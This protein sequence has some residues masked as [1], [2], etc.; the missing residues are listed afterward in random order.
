MTKRL[1]DE[2]SVVAAVLEHN[3]LWCALLVHLDPLQLFVLS[4]VSKELA[5]RV[6]RAL[7]RLGRLYMTFWWADSHCYR[8]DTCG[9]VPKCS[10]IFCVGYLAAGQRP[11]ARHTAVAVRSLRWVSPEGD[12]IHLRFREDHALWSP[13]RQ[14]YFTP[15]V[16]CPLS[17]L[18]SQ[19]RDNRVYRPRLCWQ[20]QI[21]EQQEREVA[22][23]R[24]TPL[25]ERGALFV[26]QTRGDHE[27]RT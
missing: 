12:A 21:A 18:F 2:A 24:G 25:F 26:S 7:P 22:L 1:R 4:V 3:D 16:D 19:H 23:V 10:A 13:S 11:F 8:H 6:A 5:E 27:I 20:A 17:S 14:T 9:C 15:T